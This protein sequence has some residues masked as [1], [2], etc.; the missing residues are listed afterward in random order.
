MISKLFKR[1][2]DSTKPHPHEIMGIYMGSSLHFDATF[3]RV[4]EPSLIVEGMSPTQIVEA[5]GKVPLDESSALYRFYTDDD[6]F[7][8]VL[9]DLSANTNSHSAALRLWYFYQTMAIANDDEWNQ[10]LDHNIS[11]TEAELDGYRFDP[12]WAGTSGI[13]PP[14]AMTEETYHKSGS[15]TR[16]DQFAMMYEREATAGRQEYLLKIAEEKV[17]DGQLSRC[18]VIATGF[19]LTAAHLQIN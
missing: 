4:I 8:E 18:F 11:R 15:T 7:L 14:V 13:S 12:S 1:R 16:T 6:G 9:G 19:D 10:L 5:T 2:G 17:V 3:F